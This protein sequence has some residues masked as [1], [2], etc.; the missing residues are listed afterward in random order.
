MRP[1]PFLRGLRWIAAAVLLVLAV[2]YFLPQIERT[3]LAE[4]VA[5]R[6]ITP[7][8]DLAAD[9][10]AMVEL[11]EKSKSSV[12]YITTSEQVFDL[13]S[14]NVLSVPLGTGSGLIW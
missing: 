12:V 14:R 5:P 3:F 8:G 11:F 1:S 2:W 4:T 6:V 7:R 9:E 10:R 13:R